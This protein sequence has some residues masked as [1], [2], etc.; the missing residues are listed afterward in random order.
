MKTRKKSLQIGLLVLFTLISIQ[1]HG[2]TYASIGVSVNILPRIEVIGE[3]PLNFG[4][5][6]PGDKI[7]IDLESEMAGSFIINSDKQGDVFVDFELPT[8]LSDGNGNKIP[9]NF[10]N[11]DAGIIQSRNSNT[12]QRFNPNTNKRIEVERKQRIF[13][14]C[15]LEIPENITHFGQYYAEI[16]VIVEY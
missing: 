10:K 8:Y 9:I 16:R 12:L 11:D 1:S 14:G 13:I 2:Q 6:S 4:T 7:S 3:K 15:D 5:L